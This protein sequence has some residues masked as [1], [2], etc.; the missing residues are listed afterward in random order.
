M[1]FTPLTNEAKQIL[2]SMPNIVDRLFP[3]PARFRASIPHA[4]A[5]LSQLLTA[6][7]GSRQD[8]YLSDKVNLSAY[9]RYFFPW[10]LYRLGRLLPNLPF[11]LHSGD[12]IVDLGSGPLTFPIGLWIS[13]PDLREKA[14]EFRCVDRSGSALEAGRQI[15]AALGNSTWKIKT[16][17]DSLNAAIRGEKAALVSGLD[18]F[19]ESYE[20]LPYN[21][22]LV[23]TA[24]KIARLL[25]SRA[26][27]KASFFIMEPGVPHSGEFISCLRNEL[28]EQQFAPVSPCT[29]SEKCPFREQKWCHFAFGTK[30]APASLHTLSVAARIPKNRATLSFLFAGGEPGSDRDARVLSD[31]FPVH[32]G[33]YGRYTCSRYG[34]V[35]ITGKQQHIEQQESGSVVQLF[36]SPSHSDPKSNAFLSPE[37]E[38]R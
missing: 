33:Q 8:S 35:L 22:S 1:L 14:L 19:N 13:R 23:P 20:H 12:A 26:T 36:R 2:D 6:A 27:E 29:H 7:R 37:P 34:A 31:A 3:V 38:W 18:V 25:T 28:I 4:V 32:N 17:R 15:L 16:I 9:L 11:R 10:N 5:D 24:Q 21:E 30:D